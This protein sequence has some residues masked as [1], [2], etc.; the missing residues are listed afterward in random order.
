MSNGVVSTFWAAASTDDDT[1]N[2]NRTEFFTEVE[3]LIITTLCCV[4]Q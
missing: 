1:S 2:A 4:Y 3:R